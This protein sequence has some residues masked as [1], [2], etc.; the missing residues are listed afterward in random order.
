MGVVP[1]QLEEEILEKAYKPEFQDYA[2]I[3]SWAKRRVIN[4]RQ[5]ELSELSRRP[6]VSHVKTLR[7]GKEYGVEEPEQAP[8]LTWSNIKTEIVAAM[9]EAV[10]QVPPPPSPLVDALTTQ[11]PPKRTG[12]RDARA[13]SKSPR[14]KFFFKGCWHCGKVFTGNEPRHS[15]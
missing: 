15:R 13:R 14:D 2:S 10:G 7:R 8:D 4:V 11:R 12:D 5:K 9:R 3:I 6:P 1:R